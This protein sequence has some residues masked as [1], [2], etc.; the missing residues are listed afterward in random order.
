MTLTQ[1]TPIKDSLREESRLGAVGR[2]TWVASRHLGLNFIGPFALGD[3]SPIGSPA[4]VTVTVEP[5]RPVAQDSPGPTLAA[6]VA[7]GE[8]IYT[9][10]SAGNGYVFRFHGLCEFRV[11][12]DGSAVRCFPGPTMNEG[13][14]HVLLTGAITALLVALRGHAVLHASAIT[15]GH[16]TI[17]FA[18]PSGMGKTTAA[19][20]CCAAGARFISDD[21]VSLEGERGG[22]ACVGLGSELR[23][24]QQAMGIAELFPP[25]PLERRTTA[26]GRLAIRPPRPRQEHNLISAVVLPLPVR[27]P[28]HVTVRRLLP[29][30]GVAALLAN[31]RI[32]GMVPPDWQRT[33][34]E[35]TAN[36]VARVP[37]LEATV[38]WGPPFTATVAS[39]LLS[40]TTHAAREAVGAGRD[41][42]TGA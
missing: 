19:A 16:H 4:D 34:F 37:V 12:E 23:L 9:L 33:H 7:Q 28:E 18:G 26:D 30:Q 2:S 1:V 42:D 36:L 5:S 20:L 32:P 27:G 41:P 35:A 15:Y 25:P 38:P 14:L 31:A 3:P 21:V 29:A 39:E 17:V 24:R 8:E 11:S 13:F 40:L 10:Y 22:I 6:M